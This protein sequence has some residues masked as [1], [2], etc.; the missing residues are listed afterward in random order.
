M[1]EIFLGAA[2]GERRIED[3]SELM[4]VRLEGRGPAR[5]LMHIYG[6]EEFER[7]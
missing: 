5:R 6:N 2:A 3:H 1:S 4:S 7:G